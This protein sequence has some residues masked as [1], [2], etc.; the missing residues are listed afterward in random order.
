MSRES[1]SSRAETLA[2]HLLVHG[3]SLEVSELLA[4]LDAVTI[5]DVRR[6]ARQLIASKPTVAT[7]GP[8]GKG[9]GRDPYAAITGRLA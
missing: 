5:D 9:A 3:R 8:A 4:K 2:Q 7:L 1:T 6:V